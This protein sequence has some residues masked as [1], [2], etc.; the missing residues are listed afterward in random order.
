MHCVCSTKCTVHSIQGSIVQCSTVCNVGVA[1]RGVG[2]GL[3]VFVFECLV[4]CS[5]VGVGV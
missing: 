2:V 4:V 5:S 3:L 1:W